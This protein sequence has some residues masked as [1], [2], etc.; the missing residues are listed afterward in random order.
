MS[1]KAL[2]VLVLV[3]VLLLVVFGS[4][5]ADALSRWLLQLHGHG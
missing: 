1:R 3:C 4:R 2:L 5:V